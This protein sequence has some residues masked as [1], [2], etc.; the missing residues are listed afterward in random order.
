MV[1]Y[2]APSRYLTPTRPRHYIWRIVWNGCVFCPSF[3]GWTGSRRASWRSET[4]EQCDNWSFNR[5]RDPMFWRRRIYPE[6]DQQRETADVQDCAQQDELTGQLRFDLLLLADHPAPT[7]IRDS[8]PRAC[9]RCCPV[10]ASADTV[11]TSILRRLWRTRRT[12]RM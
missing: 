12:N 10:A 4:T 6:N 1:V 8:A 2:L 5:Q 11:D 9:R 3:D 7:G